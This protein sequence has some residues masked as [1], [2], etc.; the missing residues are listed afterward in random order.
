MRKPSAPTAEDS[1]ALFSKYNQYG[2]MLDANEEMPSREGSTDIEK[3]TLI[4]SLPV[5]KLVTILTQASLSQN[6]HGR[7]HIHIYIYIYNSLSLSCLFCIAITKW[8][9]NPMIVFKKKG[10]DLW[11]EIALFCA[12]VWVISYVW[13]IVWFT[14]FPAGYTYTVFDEVSAFQI[15][16]SQSWRPEAK[17]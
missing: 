3:H 4:I 12:R 1:R 2:E 17:K 11:W 13:P 9:I 7:M 6:G 16:N 15:Q 5:A 10:G 14:N 8:T